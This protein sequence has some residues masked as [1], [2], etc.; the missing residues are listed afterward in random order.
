MT[1]SGLGTVGMAELQLPL[2]ARGGSGKGAGGC[3]RWM[4]AALAAADALQQWG[5][6]WETLSAGDLAQHSLS[7]VMGSWSLSGVA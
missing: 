7:G 2:A 4:G 6:W 3:V 1:L 5:G